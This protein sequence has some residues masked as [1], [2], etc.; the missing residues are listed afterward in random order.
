M[1][2]NKQVIDD[3]RAGNGQVGGLFEGARLLLL[4]TTDARSGTPRTTPLAYLPDGVDRMLVVASAEAAPDDP[5]WFHEL[6]VD[7]HAVVETGVLIFDVEAQVLEGAERDAA[8]AR[9]VEDDPDSYRAGATPAVPV[10]AFRVLGPPRDNAPT[11]GAYL[12]LVHDGFRRELALIRKELADSGRPGLGTQLRINC[13]TVCQGLHHHHTG[14]DTMMFP[15]LAE[16]HPSLAPVL[17]RLAEEHE[18]ITVLLRELQQAISGED[19]AQVQAEVERLVDELEAH[20]LYE[21]E[22]L[23][24]I[25]DLV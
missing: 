3:F 17:E 23:I 2:D 1:N 15:G 6:E 10:V 11:G 12:K 4:T 9:A 13:L 22:Q 8:F 20:L 21:E 25:L 14:E 18:R 16:R 24:P 7:P 19:P 5:S